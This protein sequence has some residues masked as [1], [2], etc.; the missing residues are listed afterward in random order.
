MSERGMVAIRANVKE[1]NGLTLKDHVRV[2]AIMI[3]ATDNSWT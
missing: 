3:S 1:C 2:D